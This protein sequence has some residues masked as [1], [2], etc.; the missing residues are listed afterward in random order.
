MEKLPFPLSFD[1][2]AMIQAISEAHFAL[3]EL[4]GVMNLI[5]SPRIILNLILL[6]EAKDSSAIELIMT[7]L[8]DLLLEQLTPQLANSSA[9]EVLAYKRA[10]EVGVAYIQTNQ[11]I[12][13]KLLVLLQSL[14]EPGKSGL[15]LIPGTVIKNTATNEII[16]RPPQEKKTINAYLSNL[17]R[18]INEI[19]DVDPLV[20]MALVHYQFEAIHPFYDGNGRTGRILNLLL[21]MKSGK[22]RHPILYLSKFIHE[23]KSRYYQTLRRTNEDLANIEEFVLFMLQGIK[24]MAHYSLI[25][26]LQ[27]QQSM[28]LTK[29][30]LEQRLPQLPA[31]EL[32]QH[33]Y[34]NLYTKN[35]L[36]R[37][38]LGLSRP[39]ATKYLRLLRDHGFVIET[40]FKKEYI[41]KN[42]QVMNLYPS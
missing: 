32:V 13:V 18:Y 23:H 5:P 30:L 17:E 10:M 40:R 27:I 36:L 39:T 34:K 28:A 11:S 22:L 33:L 31:E 12:T 37:E 38:E 4:N 15:R 41:Y 20:K 6:I 8:D 1:S 25:L 9:K 21:L 26:I 24:E 16:Y 7:T 14:I 19:H 35:Q 3:G 29:T 2:P 42:T